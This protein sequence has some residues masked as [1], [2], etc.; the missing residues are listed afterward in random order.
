MRA[1]IQCTILWGGEIVWYRSLKGRSEHLRSTTLHLT[2]TPPSTRV[3]DVCRRVTT[4]GVRMLVFLDW[5]RLLV[6][7]NLLLRVGVHSG[8]SVGCK[9][10][11]EDSGI[12]LLRR[13]NTNPR[14]WC[15]WHSMIYIQ[16]NST[17]QILINNKS[18][19]FDTVNSWYNR[20]FVLYVITQR[21]IRVPDR[22]Y[23]TKLRI[24]PF[25]PLQIVSLS[26]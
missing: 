11:V 21:L 18:L 14:T 20:F 13:F 5:K 10:N 24:P 23:F 22:V 2:D 16:R 12:L 26:L 25:R 3:L 17:T 6:Y 4:P 15:L 19:S 7:S 8:V 9:T 1:L